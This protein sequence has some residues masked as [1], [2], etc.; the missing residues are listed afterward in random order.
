MMFAKNISFEV[1]C[2]NASNV[3]LI[4]KIFKT[5]QLSITGDTL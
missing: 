4:D 2:I 3:T 5:D 1:L